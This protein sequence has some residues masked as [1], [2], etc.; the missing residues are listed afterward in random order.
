MSQ[1]TAVDDHTAG[2]DDGPQVLV[3][4]RE[5]TD[6]GQRVT[7][8]EQEVG[9]RARCHDAYLTGQAEQVGGRSGRRSQHVQRRLHLC[10]DAEFVG[11][12]RV[13]AAE[14]VRA[15]GDADSTLRRP[16]QRRQP[17]IQYRFDLLPAAARQPST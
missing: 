15:V 13:H 14:K 16:F 7:V 11:L 17:G 8:D 2:L 4:L 6:V 5:D 9:V 1:S 12:V 10:A 3:W